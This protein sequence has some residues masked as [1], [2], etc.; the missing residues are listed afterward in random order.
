MR[1]GGQYLFPE[2]PARRP[3]TALGGDI[4]AM[5][6]H[7][8][9]QVAAGAFLPSQGS[10]TCFAQ[11]RWKWEESSRAGKPG[12]A[13]PSWEG[14]SVLEQMSPWSGLAFRLLQNGYSHC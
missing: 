6:F 9:L 11:D 12:Q 7:I 10:D 8:L 2:A 13:R 1:Q 5:Q 3:S 14:L 4:W